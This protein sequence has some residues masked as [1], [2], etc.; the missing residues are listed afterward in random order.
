MNQ[1]FAMIKPDAICNKYIGNILHMIEHNGFTIL[2]MKYT[3]LSIVEAESFY[4]MHKGKSFFEELI[5]YMTSGSVVLLALEKTDAVNA[6]RELIGSTNPQTAH[7]GTI[8]RMYGESVGNNAVHG[9]DSVESASREL[10]FFFKDLT[11]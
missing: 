9:S 11:L 8:R 10:G 7:L 1:T 5:Q 4:E 2:R 3:T 6:W